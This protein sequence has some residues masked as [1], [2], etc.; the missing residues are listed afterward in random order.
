MAGTNHDMTNKS[1]NVGPFV[2]LYLLISLLGLL[3]DAFRL[4]DRSSTRFRSLRA[5]C[6]I[7]NCPLG[8]LEALSLDELDDNCLLAFSTSYNNK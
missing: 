6:S 2:G 5:N 4:Y 7:D 3:S 8:C 1:N